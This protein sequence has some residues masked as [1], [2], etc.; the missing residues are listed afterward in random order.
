APAPVADA[1]AEVV[2]PAEEEDV[3]FVEALARMAV[4]KGEERESEDYGEEEDEEEYE[5][6]TM[7]VPEARLSGIRFAEELL[8]RRPEEVEEP[9]GKA[10]AKKAKRAPRFVEETDEAMEEID[11]SG[12]IH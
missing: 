4:P 6:P 11:Y 3:A 7:V 12:R 5:I 8:P 2:A 1:A 9:K 10:A